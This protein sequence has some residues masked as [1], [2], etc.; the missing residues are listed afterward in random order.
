MGSADSDFAIGI[1]VS[2]AELVD[3]LRSAVVNAPTAR[4]KDRLQST[5]RELVDLAR[6]S[7]A[8]AVEVDT[9]FESLRASVHDFYVRKGRLLRSLG[10]RRDSEYKSLELGTNERRMDGALLAPLDATMKVVHAPGGEALI[11]DG[12]LQRR[13]PLDVFFAV[14]NITYSVSIE[15]YSPAPGTKQVSM[16]GG[17]EEIVTFP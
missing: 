1:T 7:G 9:P 5:Y 11:D 6:A 3:A 13:K 12:I 17:Q 8:K 15:D 4:D 14:E 2:W 10:H 16:S